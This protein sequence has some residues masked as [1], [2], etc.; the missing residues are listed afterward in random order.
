MRSVASV[1]V[2]LVLCACTA[3]DDPDGDGSAS[4]TGSPDNA[5]QICEAPADCY[6]GVDPADLA[7]LPTPAPG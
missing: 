1:F 2:A 6:P 5:G 4:G 7:D 3:D